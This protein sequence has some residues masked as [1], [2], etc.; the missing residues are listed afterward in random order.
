MLLA[1]I[2]ALCLFAAFYFA[3]LVW[4]QSGFN[5]LKPGSNVQRPFVSVIIAARNEVEDIGSCLESLVAQDYPADKHEF[6]IVNDRSG[7]RTPYIVDEFVRRDNRFQLLTISDTHT[8]MARKKWALHRGIEQARG[9]IIL[10][11][12]ADCVVKPGWISSMIRYFTD[13]VGLVAGFSPLDRIDIPSVFHR[14]IRLDGLALA[15][16]AAGS[17]G[18]GMPLTCN[19]RNLAYRKSVYEEVGG[20]SAIGSFI[21][22]DDDLFMHL[23]R[24]NTRWHL[25]YNI[26]AASAVSSRPLTDFIQFVHQ[27]LRHASKTRHYPVGLTMGLVA[28][29]LFNLFLLTVVFV[30][31]M[32]PV[33]IVIFGMKS[34]LEFCLVLRMVRMFR[35]QG[36]LRFFPLAML[37]H[38][39]YVVVFGLWGLL[40]RFKWKGEVF[41]T[42]KVSTLP[43]D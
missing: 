18:A 39:P 29:Y 17:F 28:V 31:K 23:V 10:T 27:R 20:F 6:I 41:R 32:W 19:G 30:P 33:F 12:D 5:R 7:D 21:S 22:G 24:R 1:F 25:R 42:K 14:L 3:V 4:L 2:I 26:D 37:L 8:D 16:V 38:V 35:L 36:W 43:S 11:T 15:G 34:I 40:G 9:E 13:D